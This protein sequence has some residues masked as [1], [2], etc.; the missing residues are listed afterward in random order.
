M[1][2]IQAMEICYIQDGNSVMAG[3]EG[4]RVC[5]RILHTAGAHNNIV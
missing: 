1:M 2:F 4:K 3:A 5:G